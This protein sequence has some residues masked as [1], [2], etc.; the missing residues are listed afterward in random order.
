MVTILTVGLTGDVGA[1]KS[2]LASLWREM[3]AKVID[4]DEIAKR[5]WSDLKV[6][7]KVES[8]WGSAFFKGDLKNVYAKIAAKIFSDA[9]EYK[10]ATKIIHEATF[11]EIQNILAESCRWVVLEIPL[12]FE[13]G[14]YDW[15]DYVVYAAAP[16]EKRIE[17]NSVR[18]WDESEMSRRENW[19]MPRD[20]KISRSSFVLENNGTMEEWKEKGRALGRFFLKK[21][22]DNAL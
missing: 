21:L 17:W 1:G 19:F 2:A 10:F 20:E 6:R 13:S 9:A 11:K 5:Q 16:R 14:H 8:R 7:R 15:L 12:F 4:A 22:E 3:G 18:G